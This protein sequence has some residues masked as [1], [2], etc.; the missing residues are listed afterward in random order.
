MEQGST[1]KIDTANNK[2]MSKKLRNAIYVY[3]FAHCRSSLNKHVRAYR[4]LFN[5][6]RKAEHDSLVENERWRVLPHEHV[7][8]T[9]ILSI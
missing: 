2:L 3:Q 6:H 9:F 8:P 5:V 1:T 4:I 7:L